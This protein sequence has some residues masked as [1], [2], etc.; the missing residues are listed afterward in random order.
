MLGACRQR[1][2]N[3]QR[4]RAEKKRRAVNAGE[5]FRAGADGKIRA[6][7][8]HKAARARAF[9]NDEN[10]R[11]K[12]RGERERRTDDYGW[13]GLCDIA[14]RFSNFFLRER[15]IE[16]YDLTLAAIRRK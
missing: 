14:P 16:K 7:V 2:I 6:L 12:R 1:R 15:A 11:G 10:Q 8:A 13:A 9:E 4:G 3:K 5:F